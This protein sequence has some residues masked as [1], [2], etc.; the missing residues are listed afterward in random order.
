MWLTLTGA[1]RENNGEESCSESALVGYSYLQHK[2]FKQLQKRHSQFFLITS[3][4]PHSS[5]EGRKISGTTIRILR[6]LGGLM[7]QIHS[8]LAG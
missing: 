7:F 4:S 3:T 2:D 1:H 8:T 5:S 6:L